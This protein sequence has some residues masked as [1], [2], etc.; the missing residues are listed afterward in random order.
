MRL[1]SG[2]VNATAV[3]ES[4][5]ATLLLSGTGDVKT[6]PAQA[7]SSIPGPTNPAKVSPAAKPLGT[8]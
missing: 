6:S 4:V 5:E 2:H 3:P 1:G 7:A 8:Q